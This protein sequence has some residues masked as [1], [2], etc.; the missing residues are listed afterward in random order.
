[1]RT[2]TGSNPRT[3]LALLPRR[4]PGPRSET[5]VMRALRRVTTTFAPG[6]RPSPGKDF[7]ARQRRPGQYSPF[8]AKVGIQRFVIF[9]FASP[10]KAG[11]QERDGR[12][13][14]VA[15]SYDDLRYWAPAF[16]GEGLLGEAAR[17]WSVFPV[18]PRR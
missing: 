9:F 1:M 11:A 15:P 8:P 7:W 16:A 17:T 14:R 6:P 13:A 2:F 3:L 5:V 10:A 18:V 4:R 12:N